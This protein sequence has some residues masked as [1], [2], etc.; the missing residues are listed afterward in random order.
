MKNFVIHNMT[1]TGL[2]SKRYMIMNTAQDIQQKHYTFSAKLVWSINYGLE[3]YIHANNAP[4]TF[5]TTN[6]T[7]WAIYLL[8]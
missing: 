8:C 7:Q 5:S 3:M 1:E 2:W 4:Q 6:I